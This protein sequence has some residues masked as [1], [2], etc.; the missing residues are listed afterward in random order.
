MFV[1][2]AKCT[3]WEE[4]IQASVMPTNSLHTLNLPKELI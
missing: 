3:T 4:L 1:F 2:T